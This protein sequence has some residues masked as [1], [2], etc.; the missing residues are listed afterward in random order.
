[1]PVHAEPWFQHAAAHLDALVWTA[2]RSLCQLRGDAAAVG[3]PD[4]DV[5]RVVALRMADGHYRLSGGLL[6]AA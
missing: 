2:P 3:L 6:A 5:E 4:D 1:M